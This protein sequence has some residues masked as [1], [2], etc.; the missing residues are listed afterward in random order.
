M[1]WKGE[2]SYLIHLLLI[3]SIRRSRLLRVIA[4]HRCYT[5]FKGILKVYILYVGLEL[6]EMLAQSV[7][8]TL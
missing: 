5:P 4:V 3:R 8:L 1:Y 6:K 7:S 2:L